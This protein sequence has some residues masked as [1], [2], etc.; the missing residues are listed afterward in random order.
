MR[1]FLLTSFF[2]ALAL[3]LSAQT[4]AFQVNNSDFETWKDVNEPGDGWYSFVSA[5]TSGLG[6]LG[7]MAKNSSQKNTV[8]VMLFYSN[9][10]VFGVRKPMAI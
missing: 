6:F 1:H 3:S 8:K 10:A 5:N 2:A 9:Q 7:S 4:G